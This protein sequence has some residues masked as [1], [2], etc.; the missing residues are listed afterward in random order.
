MKEGE[1]EFYMS[2]LFQDIPTT[3][4]CLWKNTTALS[5]FALTTPTAGD[6]NN[7]SLVLTLK[8]DTPTSPCLEFADNFAN[9]RTFEKRAPD[10]H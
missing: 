9:F 8:V 1:A 3:V 4:G 10:L 5:V 2:E 7:L 6:S